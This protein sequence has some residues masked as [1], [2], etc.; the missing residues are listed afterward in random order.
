MK[1]VMKSALNKGSLTHKKFAIHC[2]FR[3]EHLHIPGPDGEGTHV[4]REEVHVVRDGDD[5]VWLWQAS[6][7]CVIIKT[8]LTA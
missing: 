4:T 1:N 6:V 8:S 3:G 7:D 5:Q 2:K